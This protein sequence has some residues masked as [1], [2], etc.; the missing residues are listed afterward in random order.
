MDDL[1]IEPTPNVW[2]T[3]A[4]L[5]KALETIKPAVAAKSTL[6]V[7]SHVEVTAEGNELRLAA[8]NLSIGLIVW[9]TARVDLPC[10]ICLPAELLANVVGGLPDQPLSLT[11]TEPNQTMH[12]ECTLDHAITIKGMSIAEFPTLPEFA[13]Q[14]IVV[15]KSDQLARALDSVTYASATDDT[16][17]VLS[18][19]HMKIERERVLFSCSDGFRATRA[20][21]HLAEPLDRPDLPLELC[22]QADSLADL[23][24]ILRDSDPVDVQMRQDASSGFITFEAEGVA[25]VARVRLLARL[26]EGRFPEIDRMI[27]VEFAARMVMAR[28][29][30]SKAVKLASFFAK[31]AANIIRIAYEEGVGGMPGRLTITTNAA[32]VGDHKSLVAA[33]VNGEQGR[34]ALNVVLLQ[35]MLTAITTDRVAIETQGAQYAAIFRPVGDEDTKHV[36][37][38]MTV[39]DV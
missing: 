13:S 19:V 16:R 37:M 34:M 39:R 38:P 25:G 26:I 27:P 24:A 22:P 7:L 11:Y 9:I 8:T 18:A 31:A 36:I 10:A 12:L 20:I 28:G 5:K 23:A 2:T 33:I 1:A 17:P 15:F 29:E 21:I 14:P 6:P 30:L 3:Q 35:E 32:E 4:S